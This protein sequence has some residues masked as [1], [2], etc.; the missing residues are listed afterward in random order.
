MHRV[1]IAA[2]DLRGKLCALHC[3]NALDEWKK[4]KLLISPP[5]VANNDTSKASSIVAAN[6]VWKPAPTSDR[7][8][9]DSGCSVQQRQKPTTSSSDDGGDSESAAAKSMQRLTAACVREP[10]GRYRVVLRGQDFLGLG[11]DICGQW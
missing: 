2:N 3:T 5:L 10:L 6:T 1:T 9:L 8:S 4:S 7:D 11:F